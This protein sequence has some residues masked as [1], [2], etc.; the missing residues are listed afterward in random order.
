MK[1]E[2]FPSH[3][4]VD[5]TLISGDSRGTTVFVTCD[6]CGSRRWIRAT[7]VRSRIL[8]GT[9]TGRCDR[10]KRGNVGV[11]TGPPHSAV[12]WSDAR[13]VPPRGEAVADVSCPV[14]SERRQVRVT[15][16]RRRIL[17]GA[18]TGRCRRH[19]LGQALEAAHPTVDWTTFRRAPTGWVVSVACPL[20]PARREVRA[21]AV[22]YE[23]RKG[24]FTGRCATH[25]RRPIGA[26]T[27]R[28]GER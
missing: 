14:C 25:R 21:R 4:A 5:W 16:L 3:P 13:R 9:F 6:V 23:L 11:L 10:H 24:E 27:A 22:R 2:L 18:F 26:D 12:D 20:C 28:E 17:R 8:R 19:P 7:A 1:P 15:E